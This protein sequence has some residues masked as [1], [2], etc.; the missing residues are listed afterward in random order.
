VDGEKIMSTWLMLVICGLA[1]FL[2]RLSFIAVF[3]KREIPHWLR[4]SLQYVPV[5]V[6][7]VII[8]Q[9]LFYPIDRLNFSLSNTRL[10]AGLIAGLVAWF[11][12][13]AILTILVGIV[14]LVGLNFMFG[15]FP[16]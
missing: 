14:A 1:T 5:A 10:L 12:R 3:G 6:L 16:V 8:C 11:S 7:S 13:N 4:S 9:S 15:L 2:T